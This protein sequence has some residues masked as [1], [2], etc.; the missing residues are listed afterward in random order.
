[1]TS[2]RTVAATLVALATTGAAL[3][4]PAT[5][6]YAADPVLHTAAGLSVRD[7]DGGTLQA[8]TASV[9]W[10]ADAE[11]AGEVAATTTPAALRSGY[12][13]T[14]TGTRTVAGSTGAR[15]TVAEA[16]VELRGRVPLT[17]RGLTVGCA[18]GGRSFVTVEQLL[19]G[20]VD[21][22]AAA[23]E[24]AGTTIPLP[25][26]AGA[27]DDDATVTLE[28]VT[29]A[30]TAR[31]TTG[32]R[33]R[34]GD[35][36]EVRDL[37]LG[38]VTCTDIAPSARE[39]HR[40]AGVQIVGAD[41]VRLV[42]PA[43]V[44]TGPGA[45]SVAVDEVRALGARSRATGVSATTA[46]DGSVDVEVDAFAQLPAEDALAEYRPS[47]LRVNHLHLHVTPAGA[48]TV[49]FADSVNALFADGRWLNHQDGYIYSKVDEDGEVL[50]EVRVNERIEHADGTTTV[51]ALHYVDHT[52]SWPEV[53][54]G[55]V[56]I[57]VDDGPGTGPEPEPQPEQPV[58]PAGTWHGYGVRATG[59]VELDAAPLATLTTTTGVLDTLADGTGQVTATGLRTTVAT[60]GASSV[61]GR[62][63]LFPGTDAAVRL[64]DLRT[65]VTAAGAV[66][67]SGGGTVLG[68][69]V[70]AGR[71]TP[72]TS[73]RLA[74]TSTTVVLGATS[75]DGAG[76]PVVHGLLLTS[77]D[78]LATTVSAASVTVGRIAAAATSVTATAA[79][80]SYGAGAVLRVRVGGA[81]TGTVRATEKGRVL[82]S[83]TVRAGVA[84]VRLPR[85][86]GAGTHRLAVVF[87]PSAG[88]APSRSTVDV[89]VAKA[90][91]RLVVSGSG[92]RL[93]VRVAG[94]PV[95][96][97]G[98]VLRTSTGRRPVVTRV[99]AGTTRVALRGLPRGTHRVRVLLPATA[100][101][102]RAAAVVRVRVR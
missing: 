30:G 73:Y 51:N 57:G 24:A 35:N 86:L 3:A 53:I 97:A 48:S 32:L 82:A 102:A 42:E 11:V 15:S 34:N 56:V 31:T 98:L 23:Q 49:T 13:I 66:V 41:G 36:Y 95:R 71:I 10:A 8:P 50:L 27:Y 29:T 93:R 79:R 65:V 62:L 87:A 38:Q 45:A 20:D 22:T 52:G 44:I 25:A 89:R 84:T 101:T 100:D 46:A 39:P 68:H 81:S 70:A 99:A 63:D 40:V 21:R 94:L 19:V 47:A 60:T 12:V 72:G 2:I 85:R 78:E 59:S 92:P 43:P 6:A 91:P 61:V 33:I 16:R 64:T 55:Q 28:A 7:I 69:P 75:T 77:P 37:A 88:A 4:L 67:S 54:L 26:T 58:V 83:G 76:L 96:P 17:L 74:G 5:P 18:P 9:G 90:R 14:T 80:T 1:M